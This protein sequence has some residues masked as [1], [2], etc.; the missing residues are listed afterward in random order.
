MHNSSDISSQ[1]MTIANKSD[2]KKKYAAIIIHRNKIISYG[3]N[4]HTR[5]TTNCKQ[6]LL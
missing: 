1:L 5:I 2:V 3:F 4:H 6:C